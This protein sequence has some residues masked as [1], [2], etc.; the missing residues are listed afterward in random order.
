MGKRVYAKEAEGSAFTLFGSP[1]WDIVCGE[2]G[3]MFRA[4]LVLTKTPYAICD[5]CRSVNYIRGITYGE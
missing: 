5:S 4:K 1:K 2:C 3:H